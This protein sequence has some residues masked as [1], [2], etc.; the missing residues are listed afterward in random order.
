MFLRLF[1]PF[2]LP[3]VLQRLLP[4]FPQPRVFLR[5]LPPFLPPRVLQRLL[6]PFPQPRV[7]LRLLPPF[8]PPRVLQR[9]LP[10]FLQLRVL[11]ERN[12]R[13]LLR[14][15]FLLNLLRRAVYP[16]CKESYNLPP[17]SFRSFPNPQVRYPRVP[18]QISSRVPIVLSPSSAFLQTSSCHPCLWGSTSYSR[19]LWG[20]ARRTLR[21]SFLLPPSALSAHDDTR[22]FHS[23]SLLLRLSSYIVRYSF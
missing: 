17:R 9:L 12:R 15:R 5:L 11:R 1:P 19:R 20:R 23:S 14:P 7:L 6:P 22:T 13:D 2:L 8:L 10:P 21:A 4:P 16:I 18:S 3:R